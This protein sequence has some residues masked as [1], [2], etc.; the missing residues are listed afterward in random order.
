LIRAAAYEDRGIKTIEYG[1][2]MRIPEYW[3][4]WTDV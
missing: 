3:S 2:P 4:R 1:V